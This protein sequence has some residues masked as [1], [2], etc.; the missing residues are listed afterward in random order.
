M[1]DREVEGEIKVEDLF[2]SVFVFVVIS[3]M[4]VDVCFKVVGMVF[5]EEKFNLFSEEGEEFF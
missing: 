5:M 4:V 1:L 2:F 3:V